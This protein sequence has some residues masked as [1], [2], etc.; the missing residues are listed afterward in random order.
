MLAF[1]I[2]MFIGFNLG[3][4]LMAIMAAGSDADDVMERAL[5]ERGQ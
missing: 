1:I 2:G 5:Q 4:I 3:V